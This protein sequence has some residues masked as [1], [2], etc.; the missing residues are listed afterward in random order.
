MADR[1]R[2]GCGNRRLSQPL[3]G[4]ATFEGEIGTELPMLKPLTCMPGLCGEAD[5]DLGGSGVDKMDR[6]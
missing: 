2:C 3:V 1:D 5:T 4:A 6:N